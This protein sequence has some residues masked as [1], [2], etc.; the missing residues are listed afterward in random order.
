MKLNAPLI[1]IISFIFQGFYQT[2]EVDSMVYMK[3]N[4]PTVA[5]PGMWRQTVEIIRKSDN[6]LAGCYRRRIKVTP[7]YGS[8][9]DGKHNI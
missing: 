1:K 2:R 5:L 7:V 8:K 4:L 6:E 9:P 3:I